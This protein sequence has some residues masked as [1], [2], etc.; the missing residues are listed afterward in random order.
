LGGFW[1]LRIF[2]GVR[3]GIFWRFEIWGENLKILKTKEI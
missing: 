3:R 2:E 1:N